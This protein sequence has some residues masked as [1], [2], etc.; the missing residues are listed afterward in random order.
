MSAPTASWPP[1]RPPR[2]PGLPL[3]GSALALRRDQLGTYE[4]AMREQGDV[5]R[6]VAGPPGWRLQ[7]YSVFSPTGAQRVLVEAAERYRK[8]NPAYVELRRFIGDGLLT[9][10]DGDWRRQRRFVAPLFTR[11]R[12]EEYAALVADEAEQLVRRWSTPASQGAPVDAHAEMTRFSMRVIARVLLGADLDA[13]VPRLQA[14]VPR[15]SAYVL[16]RGLSPRPVPHWW[17]TPANRAGARSRREVY[18]V[19]DEVLAARRTG[20]GGT[21]LLGR[22]LAARDSQGPGAA[23]EGDRL[24]E[25][26]VRDQV[27]VFLL[28][29]HETTATTLACAL[30]LL[31]RFPEVQQRVR[32]EAA[33]AAA[34]GGA[35]GPGQ[36][37]RLP[38]TE[39]VVREALRLYPPAYVVPRLSA[40][41]DVVDGCSVPA[42]SIVAVVTWAIHRRPDLWPDPQRFD[43]DRF[44]PD[45]PPRHRYA[46]L[47]F[48]AGP[49]ACIGMQLALLESVLT[50]A[51]VVRAYSVEAVSPRLAL[52][53]ATALRPAGPVPVRLRPHR[54]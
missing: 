17:P 13:A 14:E 52:A 10:Q 6:F 31:G 48:G 38:Y 15:G 50:L 41:D 46:W 35:D 54:R 49:R 28:A 1:V 36:E 47:P 27:L 30:H 24:S 3:V 16:R 21:D 11:R 43:P 18:A 40:V 26:E 8:D 32:E 33:A 22:L 45:A 25:E 29:G 19:V 4:R 53:P 37:A 39:Q 5:A 44:G 7:V 51:A 20:A 23:G 34:A 2:V 42:G 9:S 12:H